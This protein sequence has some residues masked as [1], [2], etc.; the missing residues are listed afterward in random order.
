M[1]K[2]ARFRKDAFNNQRILSGTIIRPLNAGTEYDSSPMN[3]CIRLRYSVAAG[4]KIIL[5]C[6]SL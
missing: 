2:D 1:S 5:S 4:V 3:E 6:E